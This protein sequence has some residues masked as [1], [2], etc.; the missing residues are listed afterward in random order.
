M[1]SA[2]LRPPEDLFNPPFNDFLFNLWS[3]VYVSRR[4]TASNLLRD[5]DD[6]R[7]FGP[8]RWTYKRRTAPHPPFSAVTTWSGDAA[9]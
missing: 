8:S 7:V 2:G 1:A 6:R 9:A 4:K 5:L 3:G